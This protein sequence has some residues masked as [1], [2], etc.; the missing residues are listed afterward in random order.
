MTSLLQGPNTSA[1]SSRLK[2]A[3]SSRP[4]CP[5]TRIGTQAS[6]FPRRM[7]WASHRGSPCLPPSGT[8][9]DRRI[10]HLNVA[11]PCPGQSALRIDC[12][13]ASIGRAAV[14]HRVFPPMNAGDRMLIG[15]SRRWDSLVRHPCPPCADSCISHE[16]LTGF[17]CA[18]PSLREEHQAID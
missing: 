15:W 13:S 4:C 5:A 6:V 9:S 12:L 17:Y 11:I 16:H 10:G 3:H 7:A 8:L 18:T 14:E 2:C 1:G